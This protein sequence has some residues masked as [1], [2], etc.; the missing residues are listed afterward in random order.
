VLDKKGQEVFRLD[1]L[2]GD[3]SP[4]MVTNDGKF[5]GVVLNKESDINHISDRMGLPGIRIYDMVT[6]KMV[7]EDVASS[8]AGYYE[9]LTQQ[10]ASPL[11]FYSKREHI[12]NDAKTTFVF[13]DLEGGTKYEGIFTKE[14]IN[15]GIIS[16]SDAW[17]KIIQS[18]HFHSTK[19]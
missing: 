14:Q 3:I 2:D 13:L 1:D 15:S 17:E 11:V 10:M 16:W 9:G 8:N 18:S 5:L 19:F 7:F 4:S 6:G 12:Y